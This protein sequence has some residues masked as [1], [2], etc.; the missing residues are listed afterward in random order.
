M[1]FSRFCLF[2]DFLAEKSVRWRREILT[3]ELRE[4]KLLKNG[5]IECSEEINDFHELVIGATS[6]LRNSFKGG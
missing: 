6:S 5:T 4:N 2:A 1:L 3:S